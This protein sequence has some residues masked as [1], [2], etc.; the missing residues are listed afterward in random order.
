VLE[1]ADDAVRL[2]DGRIETIERHRTTAR[3]DA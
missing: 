1:A 3:L 2:R